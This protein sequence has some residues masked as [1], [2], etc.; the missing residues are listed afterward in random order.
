MNLP[1]FGPD[2]VRAL[3]PFAILAVG[4]ALTTL[5]GAWRSRFGVQTV[6]ATLVVTAF[7]PL[8]RIAEGSGTLSFWEGSLLS[9]PFGTWITLMLL[10]TGF[11]TLLLSQPV[12][13]REGKVRAEFYGLILFSLSGM[14]LL[15]STTNMLMLF[16]A[17]E[18]TSIPL[19]V[20][21]G[22][23]REDGRSGESA[24]KYFL[25][26]SFSSAILLFG[27]ALL[28]GATGTL[29]LAAMNGGADR[30]LSIAGAL[31]IL[32]GFLFKVGAV[33]FHMWAPD[34]Y[35]GAPTPVTSFMATSV[36]VAGFAVLLRILS[37]AFAGNA[38]PLALFLGAEGAEHALRWIAII[39]MSVGNICALTQNNVKRM[40]A[41]SSI[42][43]AGYLMLG[44]IPG[45]GVM[46]G[47]GILYYLIGYVLMTSGAFAVVTALA[48]RE[49]G[50]E[51]TGID[52]YAGVGYR[53]P[54]LGLAMTVFMVSLAGIPPTA[55]FL[56][57]YLLFQGAVE[58][59]LV[60]LVVIAVLNSALSLYYY[61]RVVVVFYMKETE[62]PVRVD[63]SLSLRFAALLGVI[64]VLWFGFLPDLGGFPGVPTLLG[65]VESAAAALP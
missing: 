9:D 16:I 63:D 3:L 22:Y 15:V 51:V 52:R 10:V 42:A 8:R 47:G 33:P 65:L 55:G 27:V 21:C 61:L 36:K 1:Y 54:F 4:A 32:T 64:L 38:H 17:L 20:L 29:D 49:R 11:F 39:T 14:V 18:L 37:M 60:G 48:S 62:R 24:L 5:L 40:L 12:L 7:F 56:G 2:A 13:R 57:K 45:S 19:Y 6:F 41:Y 59:G 34:V 50:R 25:L 23:N 53:R 31:L 30:L 58:R 35:D 26:G 44:L 28:F 46:D 43:H